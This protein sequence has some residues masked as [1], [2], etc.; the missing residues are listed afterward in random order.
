MIDHLALTL[1]KKK[2]VCVGPSVYSGDVSLFVGSD[3]ERKLLLSED[4]QS[5]TC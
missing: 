3:A 4:G 1:M 5:R 2:S